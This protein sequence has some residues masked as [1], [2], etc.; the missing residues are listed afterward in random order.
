[1]G[2]LL[3]INADDWGADQSTT[4]AIWRCFDAGAVTSVSGMAFMAGSEPAA[5]LA[6]ERAVPAGLHINLTEPFTGAA[7]HAATRLRQAQIAEYFGG[8]KWRRWG[9]SPA[10]FTTIEQAI[11]EQ[12]KEFRRLYGRE[13]SHVDGHEH[14][15]QSLGV[16]AA[17]TIP[18]GVNMRPSFTYLPGEKSWLNRSVRGLVNR[19]LR[20][21]FRAPRYFFSIRDMHPA[22]GGVALEEKLALSGGSTVEVMTHPE[23]DDER[24]ILLD[25][26][27]L[28]LIG[29]RGLGSYEQL[30]ALQP[31]VGRMRRT[32]SMAR[33]GKRT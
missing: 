28:E 33:Y 17:R 2:G 8:P 3:I 31:R 1:M 13:P 18:A 5:A 25:P 14:I 22:L 27:W 30:A 26:S 32:L 16:L 6:V 20:A 10:W 4:E 21:R 11:D 24:E 9:L 29:Q 15:H 19:A 7:V 12:F 23:W